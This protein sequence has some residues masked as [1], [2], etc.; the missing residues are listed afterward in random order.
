MTFISRTFD[1]VLEHSLTH[2]HRLGQ[3][4]EYFAPLEA[5]VSGIHNDV[6]RRGQSNIGTL[7]V[8]I[9]SFESM[10]QSARKVSKVIIVA[11]IQM[12]QFRL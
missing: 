6:V 5:G 1:K 3:F 2:R 10:Q 9:D 7:K 8:E 11:R 12:N 4:E